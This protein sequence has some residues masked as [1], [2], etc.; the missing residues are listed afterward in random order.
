MEVRHLRYFT[1]VAS[2]LHFAR[3]AARLNIALPTL[4]QQIK[5]LESYLGVTLFT[6]STKKKVELTFAGHQFQ[7]RAIALIESKDP[8]WGAG[9]RARSL[10]P[11]SC[12]H[13][14]GLSRQRGQP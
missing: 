14:A 3:A 11:G 8:R 6:R 10:E 5:W 9:L 4:S 12:N 7:K 2:E 13:P 1:A